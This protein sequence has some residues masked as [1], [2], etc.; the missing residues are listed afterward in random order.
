MLVLSRKRNQSI[1]IGDDI[2]IVIN[3]VNGDTVRVGIKAPREVS[4]YRKEIY[5]EIQKANREAA[6]SSLNDL[7]AVSGLFP[8]K[9]ADDDKSPK[10]Q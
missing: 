9:K 1:M 6:S 2:E 10:D 4:V 5:E 3:D 7:S 8:P